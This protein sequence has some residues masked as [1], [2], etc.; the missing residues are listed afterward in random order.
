MRNRQ[1]Q[2]VDI[3]QENWPRYSKKLMSWGKK[4]G[5]ILSEKR[6][7]GHKNQIQNVSIYWILIEKNDNVDILG[8]SEH[9]QNIT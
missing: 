8:K 1:I 6:S 4:D 2:N 9:G 7:E 5:S 3:Q